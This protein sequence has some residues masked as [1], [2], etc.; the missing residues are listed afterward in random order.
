MLQKYR[1]QSASIY[2]C[3]NL[4]D[5]LY[6][7]EQ[8]KSGKAYREL[9]NEIEL[10]NIVF[11]YDDRRIFNKLSLKFPSNQITLLTG[12]SGS[13]KTTIL[14]LITGLLKPEEGHVNYD[15]L[16]I[17]D[18][19]LDSVRKRIG[20]VTQ[21]STLFN[22]SVR[23]NLKLRNDDVS[24]E[25]LL[26]EI[27]EFS[28]ESLFPNG[29]VDLEYVIDENAANLSGGQ[30]QRLAFIREL[31]IE[32]NIL[33]LDEATSALDDYSK[34]RIIQ[35]IRKLGGKMTIIIVSHQKEYLPIADRIYLIENGKAI[36][37]DNINIKKETAE[38]K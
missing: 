26:G 7:K 5:D 12:E 13:G 6:E 29:Q 10:S 25:R 32:P 34:N 1:T 36:R 4:I 33:I 19:D 30:K 8:I 11:K 16:A 24:D 3:E 14:G 31:L 38:R 21:E 37:T 28:L 22:L 20:L 35:Y 27:R 9:E 17:D 23:E 2:Y 18:Y 15:D